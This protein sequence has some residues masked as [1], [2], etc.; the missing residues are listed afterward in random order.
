MAVST[1]GVADAVKRSGATNAGWAEHQF[2][3]ARLIADLTVAVEVLRARGDT[4]A[5]W[6]F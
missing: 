4:I 1:L 2:Q 5:E 6:V 3:Q